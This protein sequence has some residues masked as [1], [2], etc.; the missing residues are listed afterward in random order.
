MYDRARNLAFVA[1]TGEH[2]R[3]VTVFPALGSDFRLTIDIRVSSEARRAAAYRQ[4]VQ[5]PAFRARRTGIVMDA[6]INALHI[7]TRVIARAVA[8]AVA[9]DHTAAI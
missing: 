2:V 6:G 1:Q 8:V 3:T 5:D 9:A 4:V 7:D